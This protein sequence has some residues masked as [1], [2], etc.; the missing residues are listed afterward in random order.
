M[1]DT[2]VLAFHATGA[3]LRDCSRFFLFFLSMGLFGL[4]VGQSPSLCLLSSLSLSLFLFL[5]S[6]CLSSAH[7][8][9]RTFAMELNAIKEGA[10]TH[11][12][13]GLS[14]KIG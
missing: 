8:A 14:P 10:T 5:S 12:P 13:T 9:C 3:S 4:S 6:L 11:L 7:I 1:S 2:S